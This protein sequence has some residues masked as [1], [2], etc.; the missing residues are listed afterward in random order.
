MFETLAFSDKPKCIA[1]GFFDG[2]HIGHQKLLELCTLFAELEPCV[3]TFAN[4]PAVCLAPEHVPAYLTDAAEKEALLYAYGAQTVYMPPFDA[5]VAKMDPEVFLDFLIR[6]LGAKAIVSGANHRFGAGAK[7]DAQLLL[8]YAE[9][10]GVTVKIAPDVLYGDQLVSATRIRACLR[11]A[12]LDDV[13]K[14]LGRPYT[15]RGKVIHGR[16]IGTRALYPTAN[17][18]FDPLRA[19]PADGVYAGIVEFEQKRLKC[20]LNIGASPTVE[21]KER[22]IEVH[23]PGFEGDLYEKQLSLTLLR[24]IRPQIRFASVEAL[25]AQI[26]Q[27][28]DIACRS[29]S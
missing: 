1:L 17:L 28:I 27:D 4:H 2:V 20:V 21:T 12:K 22:T 7:G 13:H 19:I 16:G 24:F 29:D 5:Q 8:S 9:K 26:A 23:V 10:R 6:S 18:Q 25:K 3:F 14:M 15:I 11:E